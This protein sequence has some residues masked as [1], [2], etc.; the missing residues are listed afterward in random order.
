VTDALST[1]GLAALIAHK[2]NLL[3]QI[4]ALT[5]RQGALFEGRR[6]DVLLQVFRAK[7]ALL[8]EIQQ[9]ERRLDPYRQQDPERRAWRNEEERLLA[10]RQ[11]AECE[12]LLAEI[13]AWERESEIALI[14]ERNQTT[15][16]LSEL[17]QAG[18]A[19]V[20]YTAPPA[21]SA[22]QVDLTM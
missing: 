4:H 9:V 11:A 12:S 5:R 3:R 20:A 22:S 14:Q 15:R 13:K 6:I 1:D 8:S 17:Q 18:E 19:H 16:R 7:A 2:L 10:R 21:A